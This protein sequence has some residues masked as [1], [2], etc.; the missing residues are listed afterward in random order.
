[1]IYLIMFIVM[2]SSP[3]VYVK[4]EKVASCSEISS[5]IRRCYIQGVGMLIAFN[6]DWRRRGFVQSLFAIDSERMSEVVVRVRAGME[7]Y[8]NIQA[9]A[10]GIRTNVKMV[11]R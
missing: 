8:R 11:P 1:M 3:V 7:I 2:F 4:G 6:S 5:N 10:S 9:Q